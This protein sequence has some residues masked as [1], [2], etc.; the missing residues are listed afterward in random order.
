MLKKELWL[1]IYH[2]FELFLH[3]LA[4]EKTLRIFLTIKNSAINTELSLQNII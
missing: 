3:N 2:S 4:K 1:Q